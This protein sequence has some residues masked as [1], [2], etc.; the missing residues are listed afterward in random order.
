MY[1]RV[2][3]CRCILMLAFACVMAYILLGTRPIMGPVF[4]DEKDFFQ[5]VGIYLAARELRENGE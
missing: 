3:M 1:A 4:P 5:M 2:N